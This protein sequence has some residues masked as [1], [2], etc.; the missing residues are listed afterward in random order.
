[1]HHQQQQQHAQHQVKAD[2]QQQY[3]RQQAQ[4][5]QIAMPSQP[6]TA[7]QLIDNPRSSPAKQ[8][9]LLQV[10]P[11]YV[12]DQLKG[13][14]NPIPQKEMA[15]LRESYLKQRFALIVM[16]RQLHVANSRLNCALEGLKLA[17]ESKPF[18]KFFVQA[19]DEKRHIKSVPK[20]KGA[21]KSE[22]KK[23]SG[24]QTKMVTTK[25]GERQRPFKYST[26]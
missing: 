17:K 3:H 4:H 10:R 22:E 1:M 8:S 23:K 16:Q 19:M 14:A 12:E 7:T 5:D 6:P 9:P 18:H 11:K 21:A 15:K 24:R 20:A 13:K 26:R 2:A 25:K